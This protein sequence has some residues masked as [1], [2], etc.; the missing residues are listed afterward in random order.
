[1]S[2]PEPVAV[3]RW[4]HWCKATYQSDTLVE[5]LTMPISTIIITLEERFDSCYT[6]E[7]CQQRMREVQDHYATEMSCLNIP[8]NFMIAN[9][10]L[11]YEGRGWKE[12]PWKSRLYDDLKD[13][14]M[15]IA[16]LGRDKVKQEEALNVLHTFVI[17]CMDMKAIAD[18]YTVKSFRGETK[19]F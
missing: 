1:M 13:R 6:A 2:A 9:D 12:K 19:L 17:N 11:V 16:V 8:Y 14:T 4:D 5:A 15:D 18:N 3:V 10:G 7:E